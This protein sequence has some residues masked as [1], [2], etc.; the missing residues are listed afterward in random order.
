MI[1]KDGRNGS[2]HPWNK[3]YNGTVGL[4]YFRGF[5]GETRG[6]WPVGCDYPEYRSVEQI[7]T[8]ADMTPCAREERASQPVAQVTPVIETTA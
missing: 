5:L 2:T 6:V 1:G 3:G 4:M 8:E 7:P